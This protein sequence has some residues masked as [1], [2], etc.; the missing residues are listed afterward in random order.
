VATE[1]II[2][3]LAVMGSAFISLSETAVLAVNKIRIRHLAES[4]DKRA[5]QVQWFSRQPEKF[6]G[7]ILL[8]NNVFNMVLG[9]VAASFAIRIW[10]NTGGVVAGAAIA[11]TAFLVMF[12][13][14]T[15]KTIAAGSPERISLLVS[16]PVYWLTRVSYPV[17]V[18]FT[19][20]PRLLTNLAGGRGGL[21]SPTVTEGEL[22]MLIDVGEEEGTVERAQGAMLERVFELGETEVREIMTPRPDIVWVHADTT[23]GE[24]MKN[25]HKNPFN[26]FPVYDDDYDDV[27]GVLSAR[28]VIV[29][30]SAGNLNLDLPVIRMAREPLFVPETKQLDSLFRMMQQ[31]GHRMAVVVDEY[32]GVAGIVTLR[33]VLEQ[34]VGRTGE[35]GRR[36]E[37][38][39]ITIDE[40]TFM[41]DGGMTVTEVN[42]A[43]SLDLP[44]GDYE[45]VAGFILEQLQRVPAQGDR[46]RYGDTRLQVAGMEGNRVSQVRI[47]KRVQTPAGDEAR[48]P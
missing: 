20:L 46:V 21:T 10:G 11:A 12:G 43:L 2:I 40:N 6:F 39:F 41:V 22:R 14:L 26:R 35:E 32:G 3:I 1:I 5:G 27:A 28:D 36:P 42:E 4:G 15:P 37:Q 44:E 9:A 7:G 33:R 45:T 8:A 47:R 34:I 30:Q 23:L 31:G 13:E 18:V 24:F 38:G 19:L 17:V 16:R 25:Y 48:V 29:A